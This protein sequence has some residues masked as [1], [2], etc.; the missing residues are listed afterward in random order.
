[1]EQV[2]PGFRSDHVLT[3]QLALPEVRYSGIKVGLFYQSLLERIQKLPGVEASGMN[4]FLPFGN[5]D[6]TLNFQIQGRPPLG[7][8]E[9]P[10]AG[11]RAANPGYF[12]ALRIPLLRGRVFDA[13]DGERT[14][15]VV[16]VNEAAA[17]RYWPGENPVGK[18]ILSGLDDSEWSTIVGVVG[19]VRHT[20]LDV[21][22]KPE[23][24][25]HYLQIPP[26]WMSFAEGTIWLVIR[27]DSD[28]A[29]MTSAVRRE[30]HSLDPNLPVY[31]VSTMEELVQGSVA[32]ARFRT[33][34]L[35]VFAALALIL[36][37]IGLYGVMSYA[38]TQRTQELGV[39][40]ALGAQPADLLQLVVGHGLRLA[41]SGVGIGL[42]FALVGTRI[43]SKLLFG[44]TAVDPLTFGLTSLGMLAAA[45]AATTI[46][47]V[48]AT[49]IAPATA[50]RTE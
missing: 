40:S 23:T 49:R 38:V 32:Q 48:R 19:D 31:N 29:S 9:Q 39:R 30:V 7:T 3:M 28:P 24:Y 2:N 43:I 16:V 26:H 27:T 25:Y 41:L 4:H 50:L 37:L 22:V 35:A 18:R 11:F 14:P 8:V 42:A 45:V 15:K 36:A 46:P 12:T 10:R 1:L 6:A 20:A 34:L 47:A 33:F 21:E 44:V 17:R 13:S 5:S